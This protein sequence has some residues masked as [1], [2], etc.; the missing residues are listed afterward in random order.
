MNESNKTTDCFIEPTSGGKSATN[1]LNSDNMDPNWISEEFINTERIACVA[2][3]FC[4]T[5][6]PHEKI[7]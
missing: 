7:K 2:Q 1:D 4:I 6:N 3:A 5:T